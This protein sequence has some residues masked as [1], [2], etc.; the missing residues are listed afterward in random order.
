MGNDSGLGHIASAV[1]IKSLTIFGPGEPWRY[2]PW[3][4]KG[5]WIQSSDLKINSVN[6]DQAADEIISF[7]K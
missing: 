3:G 1:N 7:L 6:P 5:I 4:D 2:R